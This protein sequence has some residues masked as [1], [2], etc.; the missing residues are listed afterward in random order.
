MKHR[1]IFA[2][3]SL[4]L[5]CAALLSLWLI[6]TGSTATAIIPYSQWQTVGQAAPQGLR[7]QLQQNRVVPG[8]LEPAQINQMRLYKLQV[9][10]QSTSLYLV[11]TRLASLSNPQANPLCGLA[12][13]QFYIYLQK[14]NKFINVF[15][16]YLD[17]N[18]PK[19]TPMIEV[20]DRR[21]NGFPCL[22][23]NQLQIDPQNLLRKK[24]PALPFTVCF[25]GNKFKQI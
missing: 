10:G 14:G 2:Q 22:Q 13:C 25:D 8:R 19:A 9:P 21:S 23:F 11:Y 7:S 5:G 6:P 12:G 1:S 16:Q 15:E 3:T 4:L 18:L 24:E 17:P 20:S